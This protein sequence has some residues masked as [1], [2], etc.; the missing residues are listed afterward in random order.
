VFTANVTT[1]TETSSKEGAFLMLNG[2]VQP[3]NLAV[4][5]KVKELDTVFRGLEKLGALTKNT[6][7][8]FS[9]TRGAA[10]NR[11]PLHL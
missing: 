5:S 9:K 6:N 10:W 2:G 3:L 4:V 1:S 8:P 11:A 7:K